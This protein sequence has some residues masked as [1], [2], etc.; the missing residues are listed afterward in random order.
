[1]QLSNE[2]M[3]ISIMYCGSVSVLSQSDA[4]KQCT[5]VAMDHG[6]F[7]VWFKPTLQMTYNYRCCNSN[8]ICTDAHA[9]ND[10]LQLFS[11]VHTW[12]CLARSACS[13]ITILPSFT[14]YKA[15]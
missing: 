12:K 7:S 15:W 4:I 3:H 10:I 1:M 14:M 5:H 11:F 9:L 6:S 13:P 8:V 2:N